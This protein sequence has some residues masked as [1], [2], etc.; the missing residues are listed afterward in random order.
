MLWLRI[1][2]VWRPEWWCGVYSAP[3]WTAVRG[4]RR[5][6][7]IAILTAFTGAGGMDAARIGRYGGPAVIAG[8]VA[9]RGLGA[10]FRGRNREEIVKSQCSTCEGTLTS[11][12]PR[13][14]RAAR[15]NGIEFA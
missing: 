3:P 8:P 7:L 10:H 12:A 2:C 14:C 1:V 4:N 11:R 13:S 9:A 5:E 15:G 6:I